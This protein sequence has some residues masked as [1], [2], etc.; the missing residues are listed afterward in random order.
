M[1][2]PA[3]GFD[4]QIKHRRL[5]EAIE[6]IFSGGLEVGPEFLDYI[7]ATFSYPSAAQLQN[8][9]ADEADPERDGLLE[10]I[11]Y[12]DEAMQQELEDEIGAGRFDHDDLPVLAA[13]LAA[14]RIRTA[15]RLPEPRGSVEVDMPRTAI[16]PFLERLNLTRR[17]DGG[18]LQAVDA[19]IGPRQ[20]AAVRVK[21]RN[22]RR[23][24]DADKVR[25]LAR[26]LEK[27]GRE[28]DLPASLDFMLRFL[29][30]IADG[31]DIYK[32]LMRRR[33]TCL[34]YIRVAGRYA[35]SLKK[36]NIETLLLRGERVP[37]IPR[38]RLLK[39]VAAIE[40]ISLAVFGRLDPEPA[41]GG[42][43]AVQSTADL[44]ALIRRVQ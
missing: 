42:E 43:Y 41:D 9:L 6:G 17:T 38:D 20:R 31:E 5:I 37:H 7:D 2:G 11:F 16:G 24:P 26:G 14:C 12:P 39:E 44:K 30:D 10:L 15:L 1:T 29:E 27:L 40:R 28:P 3:D 4:M 22:M 36:D 8:L 32:A 34:Q 33:H 35:E 18:L 23:P 25:F 21:L 19:Y 13:G